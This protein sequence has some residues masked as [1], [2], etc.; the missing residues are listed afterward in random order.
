MTQDQQE[1]K[2]DQR[3]LEVCVRCGTCRSV[4]PAFEVLGWESKNTRGR[5]MVAKALGEGLAPDASVLDSLNTCTTCGICA[6]KCP[7]GANPPA[8]VQAARRGLVSQGI[9]TEAQAGFRTKVAG[10]GN[11]FGEVGERLAWLSDAGAIKEKAEA[12]YFVGCLDSYRYPVVAAKT[13]DILRRFGVA[14]L[15]DEKCCG[16]PLI[17]TGSSALKVIDENLR[18]IREMKAKTVVT[19]CAGCLSTLKS[20]YPPEFE[21]V[22][23]PEFLAERLS[24]LRPRRLDLTV[25]YHDP[26][27]LGRHAGI[28]DPP[29]E[30]IKAICRLVEMKRSRE[31]ARCCGGGGG[32]RAGY[33][34][35]SLEIAKRRLQDVPAGVD[36]IV[37]C[38]PLC[39]RNLSDAGAGVGAEVEVIDLVDLVARAIGPP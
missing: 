28:F 13:F 20:S 30:V 4:C 23:V 10:S 26:C 9:M 11:T 27:H 7:A 15:P 8:I 24:V 36:A 3:A 5:V 38:C 21:V 37:S 25:T 33:P 17:R 2:I 39:I 29:R 22:S 1:A 19:G 35:L 12:V 34:E 32:V 16:S 6:A 18:Q 14:L 31:D